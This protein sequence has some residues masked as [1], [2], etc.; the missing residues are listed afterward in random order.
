MNIIKKDE[1]GIGSNRKNFKFYIIKTINKNGISEI[2]KKSQK[3]N[4]KSKFQNHLIRVNQKLNNLIS[5]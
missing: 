2:K 5:R 4:L 3:E 1:A